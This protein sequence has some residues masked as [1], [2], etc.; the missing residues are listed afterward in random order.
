MTDR[1]DIIRRLSLAGLAAAAVL[2]TTPGARA[3]TFSFVT[4]A[5]AEIGGEAVS[6][7]AI[8]VLSDGQLQITVSNHEAN[9]NDDAQAL[10]AITFQV[11]EG[12]LASVGLGSSSMVT[13]VEK[14]GT[15]SFPVPISPTQW[16]LQTN[17]GAH[18][19]TF[20]VCDLC[21]GGKPQQLLIGPPD[22]SSNTYLGNGIASIF[23]HNPNLFETALFTLSS[24]KLT[25]ALSISHVIFGFGTGSDTAQGALIPPP[26]SAPEPATMPLF[27][28]GAVLLGLVGYRRRTR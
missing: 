13:M 16:E 17:T 3:N 19:T 27:A 14:S 11:D 18:S 2:S 12:S 28:A 22:L 25:P 8:F 1:R 21:V 9:P 15:Y 24:P 10:N 4:P 6:V 23:Q 26:A 5:A 20:S 7:T